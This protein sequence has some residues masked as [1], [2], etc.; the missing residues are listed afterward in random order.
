L[1]VFDLVLLE[2]IVDSDLCSI[3]FPVAPASEKM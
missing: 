3:P 1:V 2:D